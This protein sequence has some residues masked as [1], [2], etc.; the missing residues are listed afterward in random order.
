MNTICTGIPRIAAAHPSRSPVGG[1]DQSQ[2]EV[3]TNFYRQPIVPKVLIL[4]AAID[5]LTEPNVHFFNI[6]DGETR[7]SFLTKQYRRKAR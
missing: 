1:D 2:K 5:L 7:I 4:G 3:D 6:A